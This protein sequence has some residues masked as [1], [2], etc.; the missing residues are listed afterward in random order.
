MS[1]SSSSSHTINTYTFVSSNTNLPSWRIP[2]ME[3]YESK[4]VAPFSPV[5]APEYLEYL[6]PSD[7]DIAPTKDQP[8]PASPIALSPGYIADSNPIED[9]LE[10]DF[11]MDPVDYA[12]DKEEDESSED[13]EEEHLASTDS[14]LSTGLR[15]AQISIRSH[16]PPSPSIKVRIAEFEIRES[17][18]VATARQI[19]PA[20]ARGVV[21]GFIDTLDA[22]IRATDERVM[23]ALEGVNERMF[24]LAATH[25]HNSEGFYTRH[26][27]ALVD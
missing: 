1:S 8:L 22:S 10:E 13:D 4:P 19:G 5:H 11:E 14:T 16:T 9:G 15:R 25:R 6:A 27:D 3:A 21:Y 7:N 24:D 20:L 12:T 26:Q 2:L 18:T 23:T 17:S